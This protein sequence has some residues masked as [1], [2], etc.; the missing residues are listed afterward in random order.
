MSSGPQPSSRSHSR[1]FAALPTV[2]AVILFLGGL[3][4]GRWLTLLPVAQHL[5][6]TKKA[7]TLGRIVPRD[8][9]R[10]RRASAYYDPERARRD[11]DDYVWS[12]PNVPTPFVGSAPRPGHYFNTTINSVQCRNDHEIQMP[13]PPG[14]YRI[15]FTGG[16]T[17][18][19][20]GAPSQDRTIGGYLEKLLNDKLAKETNRKYEVLVLA[21]PAWLST[22]ERV[23]IEN[24]ITEFAP[25]L[26][27][28]FSGNND[29]Y[30]AVLGRNALWMR[31]HLDQNYFDAL[32]QIYPKAGGDPLVEPADNSPQSI[33]PGV[34]AARVVKN[35][36]LSAHA[37]SLVGARYVFALQPA[38]AVSSKQLSERERKN[39]ETGDAKLRTYYPGGYA[40]IRASLG[41][42]HEENFSWLDLSDVFKGHEAKEEIF[43][44]SFHFGDRG[45]DLIAQALL[46]QLRPL[47]TNSAGRS[48]QTP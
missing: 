21:N 8:P 35:A 34:M 6:A 37:L 39:L 26:V 18:F 31:T 23:A 41:Q 43:L 5:K 30:F 2:A 22:H 48:Q 25:D 1:I 4:A 9:E 46:Q 28:A 45:N 38:I 13:K 16:S 47:L 11:M 12:V 29:V 36:R 33:D 17:A 20:S 42:I 27:V 10:S 19:G 44:D 15:F 32:A 3:Y 24:R 7:Y 14:V 40:A